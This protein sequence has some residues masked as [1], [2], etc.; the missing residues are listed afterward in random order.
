MAGSAKRASPPEAGGTALL[1][2]RLDRVHHVIVWRDTAVT[3]PDRRSVESRPRRLRRELQI[4]GVVEFGAHGRR[5]VHVDG[6]A[7]AGEPKMVE[8]GAAKSSHEKLVGKG[9]L[10][11]Q[12]VQIG[13]LRIVMAHD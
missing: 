9:E 2:R 8:V 5:R 1:V 7:S 4:A 13:S 10:L 11:G 3:G 6:R 12:L